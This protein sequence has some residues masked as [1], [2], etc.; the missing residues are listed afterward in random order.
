MKEKVKDMTCVHSLHGQSSWLHSKHCKRSLQSFAFH[1]TS[2]YACEWI[3]KIAMKYLN[4]Q[5]W[6]YNW[7]DKC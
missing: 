1:G 6:S 2:F 3:V 5:L 7:E 4:A